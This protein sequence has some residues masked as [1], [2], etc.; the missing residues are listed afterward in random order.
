MWGYFCIGFID[1]MLAGKKLTVFKNMFSHY[2]FEKNDHIIL[3]YFR[4]EW[5]QFYW[6]NWQNNLT[7][8]T[9]FRSDEISKTENYFINEIYQKKSCSKKLSKYVAVFNYINQALMNYFV[10]KYCWSTSWNSKYKSYFIFF[11]NN[12]NSQK[13]TEHNKKQKE[14]AW[15]NSYAG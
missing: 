5:K 7:N 12:R 9:K 10:Y 2:D 1:S 14:K 13:I 4:D 15:E 3:T 11:S 8:Q 6:S